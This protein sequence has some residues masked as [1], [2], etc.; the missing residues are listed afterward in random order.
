MTYH[1]VDA[2]PYYRTSSEDATPKPKTH[3]TPG[4][5]PVQSAPLDENLDDIFDVDHG[6]NFT[7][8]QTKVRNPYK[9]CNSLLIERRHPT[10][11]CQNGFLS[12]QNI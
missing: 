4:M 11:S 1:E 12:D 5:T 3:K 6:E 8:R 7:Y 10:I 2:S 9:I